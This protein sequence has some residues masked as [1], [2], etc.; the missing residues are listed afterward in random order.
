MGGYMAVDCHGCGL[1]GEMGSKLFQK[2]FDCGLVD[3][4]EFLFF[5]RGGGG[6]IE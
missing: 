6:K 1:K 2:P 4:I 3:K 5:E